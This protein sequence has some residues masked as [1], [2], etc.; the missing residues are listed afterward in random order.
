MFKGIDVSAHQGRI[1]WEKVKNS[2]I[3]FAILRLGFGSDMQSQD[4]AYFEANV[5]GCESAGLP[6]G[7]YLYS[8]ALNLEDAK[9]E[10]QHALRLLK[11][12]KPKYPV[13]FDMEDADGYKKN[14]GM[15]SSQ[16]LIDICKTFLLGLE[17][18][19]YYASL[20]ANLSWFN[21]QLNSSELDRFDKWVAQWHA[22]CTYKKPYG[23]WQ[24]SD[25]GKVS[26]ISGN[27]DMNISYK[28]YPSIIKAN[29]LN[30]FKQDATQTSP[31]PT[32]P[33]ETENS[34]T[35]YIVKSGDT[36]WGI[37]ERY[38]GNGSKY[39]ELKNLNGLTY[40]TIYPGQT[41]KISTNGQSESYTTYTI[42][43]GDTLWSIARRFLSN[44]SRY[45]EIMNL[46]SLESTTIYPGQVLKIPNQ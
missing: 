34:F 45:N 9:S 7:T 29:G 32:L 8:Y 2:G 4:D 46:N 44:G 41:L 17:E 5:Q 35:T 42:Q 6:W 23:I 10:V 38:L 18:A 31:V 25:N 24:Y 26:G 28:D 20:Y 1:D 33:N 16:T 19:G 27:V 39:S 15:P 3:Q 37:A 22:S 14:H 13:F 43:K 30:G 36:L 21:N 40:D 12:K 11:N